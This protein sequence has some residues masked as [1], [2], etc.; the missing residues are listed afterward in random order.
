MAQRRSDGFTLLEVA[1]AVSLTAAMCIGVATLFTTA[2]RT[3]AMA[4]GSTVGALLVREKL[5]E[6]RALPFDDP[7][8]VP[9][10]VDTLTADLAG[11][12]DAPRIGFRR[13]WSVAPLPAHPAAIVLEVD[14]LTA[15]G[16]PVARAVLIRTR[17]AA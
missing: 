12:F 14:V 4:Q 1:I 2:A 10:G 6:L 11:Y 16:R 13:R 7:A 3:A 9:T 17:K 5:E 15:E 8:L